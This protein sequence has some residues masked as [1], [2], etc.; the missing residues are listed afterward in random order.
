MMFEAGQSTTK[1]SREKVANHVC[2]AAKVGK[3]NN[4]KQQINISTTEVTSSFYE[5]VLFG[6]SSINKHR[7]FIYEDC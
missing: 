5:K 4:Q 7:T 6:A 3:G 1:V 2:F